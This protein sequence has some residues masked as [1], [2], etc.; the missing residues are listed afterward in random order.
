MRRY[1]I[2][3][4]M[5]VWMEDIYCRYIFVFPMKIARK[6]PILQKAL[7]EMCSKSSHRRKVGSQW[8]IHPRGQDQLNLNR[9]ANVLFDKLFLKTL[10]ITSHHI[11]PG[12]IVWINRYLLVISFDV[13]SIWLTHRMAAFFLHHWCLVRWRGR[14]NKEDFPLYSSFIRAGYLPYKRKAMW[15]FDV[16]FLIILDKLFNNQLSCRWLEPQWRVCCKQKQKI[17]Q[18]AN[19]ALKSKMFIYHKNSL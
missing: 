4:A 6:G 12:Y 8:S 7:L 10:S 14:H 9:K 19:R 11:N 18:E 15:K 2:T 3:S 5:S 17:V 16:L 1:S 13:E